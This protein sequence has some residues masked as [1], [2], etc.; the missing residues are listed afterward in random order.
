[1]D[2]GVLGHGLGDRDGEK[3]LCVLDDAFCPSSVAEK[4]LEVGA[5]GE[6][7]ASARAVWVD[8]GP[9][10]RPYKSLEHW[11]QGRVPLEVN[12]L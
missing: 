3:A 5:R 1:L 11:R 10:L 9:R 12:D 7:I 8:S 6:G 4:M 2:F